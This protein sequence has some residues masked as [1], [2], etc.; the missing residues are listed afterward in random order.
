[1]RTD[2]LKR[3]CAIV[4][5]LLAIA[6]TVILIIVSNALIK[7][8]NPNHAATHLSTTI[9]A[10]LLAFSLARICQPPKPTR[11]GKWSRRSL[12]VGLVLLG[13]GAITE[14]IGAFGYR[15]NESV[16]DVLT[17]I[18]NSSFI[19]ALPGL[20]IMLIGMALGIV[21]LFQRRN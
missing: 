12:I 9:P 1:M 17:T 4:S 10:L 3:H 16:I 21:S 15:G 18:H 6:L 5:A 7:S 2:L 11:I 19:F 14:A 20:F 8:E 13:I